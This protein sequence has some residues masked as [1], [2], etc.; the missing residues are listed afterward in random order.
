MERTSRTPVIK[1]TSDDEVSL[2]SP[3]RCHRDVR[4][5]R[6]GGVFFCRRR[7]GG[8]AV[9]TPSATAEKQDGTLQTT[10]V[11]LLV[12]IGRKMTVKEVR[13]DTWAGVLSPIN[14]CEDEHREGSHGG[15]TLQCLC[16]ATG[17]INS[18]ATWLR[19]YAP[20]CCWCFE[21]LT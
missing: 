21:D 20:S 1:L 10:R 8:R 14:C 4:S 16:S 3:R 19:W 11:S 6:S 13:T 12:C 18:C 17:F 2:A 9:K 7:W 15:G 5:V